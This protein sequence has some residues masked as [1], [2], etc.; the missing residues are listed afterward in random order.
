MDATTTEA[1]ADPLA[2]Y[3]SWAS[4]LF[5]ILGAVALIGGAFVIPATP[6][7][8]SIV[9][10]V[11]VGLA[12]V[13]FIG[14]A[15]GIGRGDPWAIHGIAPVCVLLIVTGLIR[16]AIAVGSGTLT[17]PLELIAAVAV[18]TRDHRP[19]L[20]PPISESGRRRMWLAVGAL[21]V[22]QLLP[23][24]AEPA[25]RGALF[26]AREEDL[27][28]TVSVD[29]TRLS[30]PGS[31]VVAKA[32]WS[33]SVGRPFAPADD[34]L[35][36]RWSADIVGGTPDVGLVVGDYRASNEAM[37]VM[38][39]TGVSAAVLDDFRRAGLPYVDFLISRSGSEMRD[40][41]VELDLLPGTA[42]PGS[43]S[44]DL[45]AAYGYGDLWVVKSSLATCS[46]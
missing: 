24:I 36:L 9:L 21:V 15:L 26:A 6:A 7:P 10:L 2:Q 19:E 32:A 11:T 17:I 29:C 23:Y 3:R 4:V 5:A 42:S 35:V 22:S 13:I 45:Q 33:W 40:G 25:M 39:G 1:P 12:A 30:E 16:T 31:P 18:I 41:H 14:L 46:W 43:G 37:V 44:V 8:Y 38:G 34:A 20:M 27:T 28:L